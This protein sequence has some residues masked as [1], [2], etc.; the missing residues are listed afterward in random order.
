ML[1]RPQLSCPTQSGLDL[2]EYHQQPVLVTGLSDLPE[3]VFRRNDDP[4]F[5]LDGL[6][7]HRCCVCIQRPF[8]GVDITVLDMRYVL[9]NG[10]ES[11]LVLSVP[12]G[13]ECPESLAVVAAL[14]GDE[15]LLPRVFSCQLERNL[16]GFGSAAGE[17]AGVQPARG[18]ACQLLE[19]LGPLVVVERT[20][21]RYERLR[22]PLDGFDHVLVAVTDDGHSITSH[23]VH[24]LVPPLVPEQSP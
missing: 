4:S 3:K 16:D 24:V 19:E 2:I 1:G 5:T 17:V 22:L 21:A 8:E 14:H 9:E 15:P 6:Q 11:F 18:A 7:N 13:G 12:G 10:F 20:V 23:A